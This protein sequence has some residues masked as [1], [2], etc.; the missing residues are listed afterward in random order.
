MASKKVL[1][2]EIGYSL[3]KVMEID[4]KAKSPKIYN[5]FVLETPA[6]L[7]Q[8]DL[9]VDHP[10]FSETIRNRISD[11]GIRSKSVVFTISS[12]KIASREVSIPANIKENRIEGLVNLNAKDY[13]PIDL[14]EYQLTYTILQKNVTDGVEQK[15]NLLVLAA[16][17]KLL[18]SYVRFGRTLGLE[19]EALDY[20]GNSLY[21][22]VKP[23]CLNEDTRMFVKADEKNALCMVIKGDD[24]VFS[25]TITYGIDDAIETIISSNVFAGINTY[26]DALDLVCVKPCIYHTLDATGR[27]VPSAGDPERDAAVIAEK[28]KVTEALSYL[29][30]GIARVIDFYK[31]KN[32]DDPIDMIL[33]TG[34]GADVIGLNKLIAL[35][36]GIP[37]KVISNADAIKKDRDSRSASGEFIACIGASMAPL[38]LLKDSNTANVKVKEKKTHDYTVIA[39][40]FFLLCVGLSAYLMLTVLSEYNAA[41]VENTRQ[42]ARISQYESVLPVYEDYLK[43]KYTNDKLN[44][45]KSYADANNNHIVSFIEE[46]EKKMPS[47]LVVSSMVSSDTGVTLTV[48]VNT[49][50]EA[51]SLIKAFRTFDSVGSVDVNSITISNDETGRETCAF[52]VTIEYSGIYTADSQ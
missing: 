8:D 45:Y 18:D 2:I 13:F 26:L 42:K 19:T 15:M 35:E 12:T 33:L 32:S 28:V 4:Y 36:T 27:Y 47:N 37:C 11:L 24:I 52:T 38:N 43:A 5:S 30:G 25:R 31:S 22:A 6:N 51:A 9:I 20:N 50:E 40:A 1:S 48:T 10:R 21:Q 14:S 23:L 41:R 49:T 3:T 44:Y 29:T 39:V 16:P 46:M 7:F 17:K 34:I